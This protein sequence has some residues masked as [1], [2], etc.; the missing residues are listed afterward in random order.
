ML[1]KVQL[2]R[3]RAAVEPDEF[4]HLLHDF[5]QRSTLWLGQLRDASGR[6][7]W[8]ACRQTLHAWSGVAGNLG[9]SAL[10][11]QCA[12]LEATLAAGGTLDEAALMVLIDLVQPTLELLQQYQVNPPGAMTIGLSGDSDTAGATLL[13][14]EDQPLTRQLVRQL[15]GSRWHLVEAADAADALRYLRQRP[16]PQVDLL[17][18]DLNLSSPDESPVSGL[19]LLRRLPQPLPFIVLT[20]DRSTAS[21]QAAL[22]AGAL[23]YCVKPPD[24]NNLPAAIITALAW[25]AERRRQ[26]E[27][28]LVHQAIGIVMTT[29]KMTSGAAERLLRSRARAERR[30]LAELARTI[31]DAQTHLVQVAVAPGVVE[32]SANEAGR[33]C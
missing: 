4:T 23:G 11:A 10:S 6:G 13:L 32:K 18:L 8:L 22:R 28:Y 2:D 31:I 20:V 14:V 29:H 33:L 25:S 1:D 30:Q 19:D 9:A 7:D 3:L 27:Q 21:L 15:I 5:M 16:A 17:L 12:R 26:Q 24:P